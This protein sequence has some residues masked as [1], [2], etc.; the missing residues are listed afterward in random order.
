MLFEALQYLFTPCPAE[1]RALGHLSGLISLG[2]RHRRCRR[3]WA[4]VC[5]PTCGRA[6]PILEQW[7][8]KDFFTGRPI[9]ERSLER[10]RPGDQRR[11]WTS[12][13]A[14]EV[15]RALDESGLPL[16]LAVRSP[17]RL[18][19]LIGAYF[20]SL[21]LFVLSGADMVTEWLFN[22]PAD[23]EMRVADLP[24]V[25][26]FYREGPERHPRQLGDL[27]ELIRDVQ[28]LGLSVQELRRTGDPERAREAAEQN[29]GKLRLKS[30]SYKVERRL[31]DLNRAMR[32][33]HADRNMTPE[34][35][36]QKLDELVLKRNA[37]IRRALERMKDK[38]SR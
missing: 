4:P 3:A 33:V 8:N 23:P 29:R 9:V 24:V 27:Y 1:V 6:G 14:S 37:L 10:L 32:M 5:W 20:G 22:Y 31:A 35:K 7:A 25:S 13:T 12:A 34:E 15:A 2:S 30:L 18:E 17:K 16:P 28:S 26:S 21:G 38:A 11:P 36:R 19:H